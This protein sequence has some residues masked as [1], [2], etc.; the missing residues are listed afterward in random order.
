MFAAKKKKAEWHEINSMTSLFCYEVQKYKDNHDCEHIKIH[1]TPVNMSEKT[2]YIQT[3]ACFLTNY[4]QTCCSRRWSCWVFLQKWR[5]NISQEGEKFGTIFS[6]L[7][8]DG[9]DIFCVFVT[10][11]SKTQQK[12]K[13]YMLKKRGLKHFQHILVVFA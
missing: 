11:A 7:S 5:A 9:R 13:L 1:T 8:H 6:L 4:I 2:Q 3:H 10:C 12:P